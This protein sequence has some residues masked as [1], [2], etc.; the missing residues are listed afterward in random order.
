M[1]NWCHHLPTSGLQGSFS[2]LIKNIHSKTK[3]QI[4]K[5]GFKTK[6]MKNLKDELESQ[7]P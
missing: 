5:L 6:P 7:I 3:S 1:P 4:S 2:D